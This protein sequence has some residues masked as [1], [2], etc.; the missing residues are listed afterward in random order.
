MTSTHDKTLDP[1]RKEDQPLR[2]SLGGNCGSEVLA[3]P[4][5]EFP[6]QTESSDSDPICTGFYRHAESITSPKISNCLPPNDNVRSIRGDLTD[7][8]ILKK[9][10][11]SFGAAG[12]RSASSRS[13][14]IKSDA[15]V[16]RYRYHC[17]FC[18][19]GFAATNTLEGHLFLHTGVK[20]FKCALCSAEYAYKQ[21]L[22]SHLAT[23]HKISQ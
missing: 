8:S 22:V 15:Q 10:F 11:G 17:P 5:R 14:S 7:D 16:Q 3:N 1:Q 2:L 13:N 19:K 6:F 9:S 21:S 12:E 4:G 20:Q 18:Q 23:V